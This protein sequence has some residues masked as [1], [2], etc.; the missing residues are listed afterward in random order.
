MSVLLAAAGIVI[1]F[2][3]ILIPR[4]I[5]WYFVERK[6]PVDRYWSMDWE[7]PE[8]ITETCD[9]LRVPPPPKL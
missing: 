6:R 9:R 4:L 3:I 2:A 8:N 1:G 7:R 5:Y